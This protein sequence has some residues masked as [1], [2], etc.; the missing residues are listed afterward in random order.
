MKRTPMK[1]GKPVER[2]AKTAREAAA[3]KKVASAK[4]VA[5]PRKTTTVRAVTAQGDVYLNN[6]VKT[7][8]GVGKNGPL[9]TAGDTFI[10]I[11]DTWGPKK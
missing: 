8:C 4:S 9:V 10:K 11:G 3:K 7:S 2:P 6:G 5:A 1:K